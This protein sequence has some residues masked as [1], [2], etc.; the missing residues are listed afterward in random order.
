MLATVEFSPAK[1]DQGNA[2]EFTPRFTTGL[3]QYLVF[4]VSCH[5]PVTN[6][7][8]ASAL[9]LSSLATSQHALVAIYNLWMFSEQEYNMFFSE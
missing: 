1:D 3:T 6:S 9:L 5:L 7:S 4:L 8:I 2:I